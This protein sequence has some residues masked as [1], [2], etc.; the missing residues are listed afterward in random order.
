L[1][2]TPGK[3]VNQ[4]EIGYCMGVIVGEGAFTFSGKYPCVVVK[5][6]TED[7]DTLLYLQRCLGGRIYGPYPSTGVG[8]LP[9]MLWH[10]DGKALAAQIP[11]F[12]EYLP[13]S[14]KRQQFVLW[15]DQHREYFA[16]GRFG[17]G[18]NKKK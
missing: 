3:L 15:L 8:R 14:R 2:F 13:A 4:F 18:W 6:V 17:K 12:E 1:T 16:R 5:L 11:L 7:L 9:L 10:L